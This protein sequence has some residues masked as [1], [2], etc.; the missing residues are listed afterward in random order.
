[1]DRDEPAEITEVLKGIDDD[2]KRKDCFALLKLFTDITKDAPKIWH[3]NIIGFGKYTYKYESGRQGEW[4]L[5]GFAPRKNSIAVYV[6]GDIENKGSILKALGTYK[7]GSSCLYLKSLANTDMEKL[8]T[9]L[10]KSIVDIKARYR[11]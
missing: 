7:E 8:R 11:S 6:I 2:Q 9:V 5:T 3:G 10:Q 4:F 1:M